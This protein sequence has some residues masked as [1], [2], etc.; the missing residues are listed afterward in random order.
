MYS[1]ARS[2]PCRL[3]DLSGIIVVRRESASGGANRDFHV[4]ADRI[5]AA[6]SFL[7]EHNQFYRDIVI[8]EDAMH[9]L[10]EDANVCEQLQYLG[11]TE[12]DGE[13][14][15]D[16][17]VSHGNAPSAP[18]IP[19]EVLIQAAIDP[20]RVSWPNIGNVPINEFNSEGYI[21]RAFPALFPSGMC[22]LHDPSRPFRISHDQYFKHLMK[23]EDG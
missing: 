4:R 9:A 6:L 14:F 22:D 12:E 1:F 15:E 11:V 16:G 20:Q 18:N 13:Q 8:S 2:L 23:Y 5:R 3:S 19:Q 21:V 7:K 10:P 17:Q